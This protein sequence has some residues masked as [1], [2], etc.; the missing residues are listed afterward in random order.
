M[1]KV[2][3]FR[4]L[5]WVKY[6]LILVLVWLLW[7]SPK[8]NAA[9]FEGKA[10]IASV[11]AMRQTVTKQEEKLTNERDQQAMIAKRQQQILDKLNACEK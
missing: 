6:A 7:N 11:K 9:E 2:L 5:S 3:L 10:S 1:D 8:N 4:I